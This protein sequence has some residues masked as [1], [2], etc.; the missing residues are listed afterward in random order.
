M[1]QLEL[2]IEENTRPVCYVRMSQEDFARVQKMCEATG[3]SMPELFR[4]AL[5]KRKDLEQPA[6]SREDAHEIKVGVNR[7]GNN[8]NQIAKQINSGERAG[9]NESWNSFYV[10]VQD[11]RHLFLGNYAGR[12]V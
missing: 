10:A 1:E 7:L 5:L 3:E 9:W 12:K 6:L 2:K 8:V 11:L 4:K